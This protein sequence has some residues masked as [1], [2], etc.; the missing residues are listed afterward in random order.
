M[1]LDADLLVVDDEPVVLDAARR[2]LADDGLAIET[3][4]DG[5]ETV[6]LLRERRYRL[7]L[8]DIM[9]PA[10]SGLALL[11]VARERQPDTPVVMITGFATLEN[12]IT[13]FR[14]GAFDF[15]PKPFDAPEL[16]GVARRGLAFYDSGSSRDP[17]APLRRLL[18][19]KRSGGEARSL[20]TL[21][22]HAWV[23]LR[24]DGLADVGVGETF[25]HAV[26]GFRRLAASRPGETIA[27]GNACAE[28][29]ADDDT[30]YR[31]WAPLSGTV[32]LTN[33]IVTA[34]PSRASADPFGDGWLLRVR[35]GNLEEELPNLTPC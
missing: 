8:L 25:R 27:Q 24:R 23:S 33:E 15:I 2:I 16:R 22:H 3:A 32:V 10:I 17:G 35:P 7:V 30:A 9:L 5:G 11:Q 19:E 18:R 1:R 21:G 4:A 26:A 29:G 28:I 20:Y 12:A 13:S 34:E 14:A 31:I 6:A